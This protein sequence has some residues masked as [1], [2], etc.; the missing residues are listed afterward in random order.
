MLLQLRV[1]V[2]VLLWCCSSA[3]VEWDEAG[4][5]VRRPWKAPFDQLNTGAKPKTYFNQYQQ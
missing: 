2:E 1:A 4:G 3:V 5:A